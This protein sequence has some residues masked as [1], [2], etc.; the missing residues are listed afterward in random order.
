MNKVRRR[1]GSWFRDQ[2][3]EQVGPLEPP[4]PDFPR[5]VHQLEIICGELRLQLP[6][7]TTSLISEMLHEAPKSELVDVDS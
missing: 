4:I 2:V 7:A 1:I 3:I 6:A 5:I